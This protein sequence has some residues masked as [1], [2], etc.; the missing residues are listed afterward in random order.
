MGVIYKINIDGTGFTKLFDFDGLNY[1]GIPSSEL[2]LSGTNLYGTTLNGGS[3]DKGVVF[4]IDINGTGFSKLVDF[5]GS[6]GSYPYSS[7]T[8]DGTTLF[9]T[10]S[11]GGSNNLGVIFKIN[12]DGTNF[13][14]I[15]NFDGVSNGAWPMGSLT[16]SNSK[17]FGITNW[18]GSNY[19][20]ILYRI[21][22]DGDKYT[23][24]HDFKDVSDGRRS[25]ATPFIF[26]DALYA[27]TNNGGTTGSG[28]IFKYDLKP[29]VTGSISGPASILRGSVRSD[30]FCCFNF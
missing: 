20:G 7:L 28:T 14:R 30:L 10:T 26:G 16:L 9:G 11:E 8:M 23:I 5:T 22:T 27:Q 19:G 1:G 6:N 24:L 4:R 18:G 12:T 17:L 2:V 25:N 29:T 15:Y 21:N 13:S 3:N